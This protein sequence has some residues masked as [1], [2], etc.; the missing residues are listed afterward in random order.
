[1]GGSFPSPGLL[2]SVAT[3]IH[4]SP[5]E[6]CSADPHPASLPLFEMGATPQ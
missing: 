6:F 3:L 2:E 4:G 1:M 5:P